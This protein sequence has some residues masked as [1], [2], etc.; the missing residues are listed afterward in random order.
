MCATDTDQL[1]EL[2]AGALRQAPHRVPAARGSGSSLAATLRSA[3]LEAG[4][5][6][7]S[8]DLDDAALWARVDAVVAGVSAQAYAVAAALSG[9]PARRCASRVPPIVRVRELAAAQSALFVQLDRIGAEPVAGVAEFAQA[10]AQESV[11]QVRALSRR[12]P[13]SAGTPTQATRL[14]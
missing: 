11:G 9:Q 7:A 10:A 2:P 6:V 3:H 1:P 8:L 12:L 14:G 5:L 4:R 13:H